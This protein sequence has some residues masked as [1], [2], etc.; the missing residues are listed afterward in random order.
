MAEDRLGGI[1]L[2]G[3]RKI[4]MVQKD[5]EQKAVSEMKGTIIGL[6]PEKKEFPEGHRKGHHTDTCAM[7]GEIRGWNLCRQAMVER[8]GGKG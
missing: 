2:H 4:S 8:L 6:I 1:L 5:V 3:I 7:C